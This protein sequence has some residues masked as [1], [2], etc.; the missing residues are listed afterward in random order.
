MH[1]SSKNLMH[2]GHIDMKHLFRSFPGRAIMLCAACLCMTACARQPQLPPLTDAQLADLTSRYTQRETAMNTGL[3]WRINL[4]LRAGQEQDGKTES[5]RITA[6]L[7]GNDA[8]HGP[9]RLDVMAGIGA[10]IANAREDAQELVLFLPQDNCALLASGEDSRRALEA[11]GVHLP[12]D[13]TD[14]AALL[15]GRFDSLFIPDWGRAGRTSKG[16]AEVPLVNKQGFLPGKII[17]DNE[18]RP[19]FWEDPASGWIMEMAYSITPNEPDRLKALHKDGQ[20]AILVIK[21]NETPSAP[22]TDKQLELRIPR[23]TAWRALAPAR[24]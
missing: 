12:L 15:L 8:Q 23:G 2:Y 24:Q 17:L 13:L 16:L 10:T 5:R 21:T 11:L 22:Y 18:A 1:A 14:M 3:P 6:L 20:F 9:I 7:W 19:I 4:A